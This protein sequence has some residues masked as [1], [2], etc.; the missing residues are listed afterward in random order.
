MECFY[1]YV[2]NRNKRHKN[3]SGVFYAEQ[4]ID[5]NQGRP[6]SGV[7]FLNYQPIIYNKCMDEIDFRIAVKVW[8]GLAEP[9]PAMRKIEYWRYSYE[10]EGW[11]EKF[12]R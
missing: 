1:Q 6:L 5:A 4:T 10:M 7:F 11:K 8:V 9:E 12:Q 2:R 3:L